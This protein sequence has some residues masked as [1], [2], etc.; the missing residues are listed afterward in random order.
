MNNIPKKVHSGLNSFPLYFEWL[1][2]ATH[3]ICFYSCGAEDNVSLKHHTGISKSASHLLLRTTSSLTVAGFAEKPN[4]TCFP[5][6]NYSNILLPKIQNTHPAHLLQ[7]RSTIQM[8]TVSHLAF[9]FSFSN[10]A[11]SL[12][13][14]MII[15][16]FQMSKRAKPIR[17]MPATTPA[18]MGMMSGPVGQSEQG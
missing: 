11:N 16:S 13:S 8:L 12:L 18:T 10:L 6:S 1:S 3:S 5:H 9:I 17:T 15:S 7:S 14:W 4:N 2:N